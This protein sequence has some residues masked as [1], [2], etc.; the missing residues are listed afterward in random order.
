MDDQALRPL[1]DVPADGAFGQPDTVRLVD[2]PAPV[3]KTER[4]A[5]PATRRKP[6]RGAFSAVN[7]A[8]RFPWENRDCAVVSLSAACG[9]PYEEAHALLKAHGR[10]DASATYGKTI[11]AALGI[12]YQSMSR[13]PRRPTAAR[14]IRENPTGTFI[15][16]VTGHFFAL[17]DGVHVDADPSL[18]RPRARLWGYWPIPTAPL[19]ATC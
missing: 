18:Y 15:V 5:K 4:G 13:G 11:S 16:F 7:L 3:R 17:V 9:V 2:A 12:R 8:D 10:A 1:P 14:F 19:P 6:P